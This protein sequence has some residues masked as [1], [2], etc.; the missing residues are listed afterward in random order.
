M[1][2]GTMTARLFERDNRGQVLW[3]SGAPL[4]LDTIKVPEQSV[5]SLE[6]LE[7][8]TKRKRGVGDESRK[9]GRYTLNGEAEQ[10]QGGDV[11]LDAWWNEG[12]S[13][14]QVLSSLEAVVRSV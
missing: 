12:L 7:Y 10:A 5:H 13:N 4:P 2:T 9:K 1:L 8:L 14:S 11:R 6:Y 3:F